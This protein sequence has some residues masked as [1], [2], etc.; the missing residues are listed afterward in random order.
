MIIDFPRFF[1]NSVWLLV[2]DLIGGV[3][4]TLTLKHQISGINA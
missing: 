1:L 4:G 2:G 3:L